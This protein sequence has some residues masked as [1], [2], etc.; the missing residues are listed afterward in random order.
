MGNSRAG[1]KFRISEGALAMPDG[2]IPW[3]PLAA[4]KGIVAGPF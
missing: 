1:A 2:R 3:R 4:L